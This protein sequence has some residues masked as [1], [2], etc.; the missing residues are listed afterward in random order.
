MQDASANLAGKDV[1]IVCSVS[2][3]LMSPL[4][5]SDAWKMNSPSEENLPS[6]M[7]L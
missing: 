3:F 7:L 2:R 4:F 6:E 1:N 5:Y